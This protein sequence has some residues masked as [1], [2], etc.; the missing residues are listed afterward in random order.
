M[1]ANDQ[2]G[3]KDEARGFADLNYCGP[4]RVK[5][6]A[7]APPAAPVADAEAGPETGQPATPAV[8]A[9]DQG[10]D[11]QMTSSSTLVIG[12]SEQLPDEPRAY[13]LMGTSTDGVV[14]LSRHGT[15]LLRRRERGDRL[16]GSCS[17]AC[18]GLVLAGVPSSLRDARPAGADQPMEPGLGRRGRTTSTTARPRTTTGRVW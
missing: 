9:P 16:S 10:R 1:P 6:A 3:T 5:D 2:R 8:E 11:R 15:H 7:G 4:R 12:C 13:H 18:S 14:L 17:S